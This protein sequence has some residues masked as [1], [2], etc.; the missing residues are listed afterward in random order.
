MNPGLSLLNLSGC[1]LSLSV[2]CPETTFEQ[3]SPISKE[4]AFCF[5]GLSPDLLLLT[6]GTQKSFKFCGWSAQS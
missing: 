5:N 4:D 6:S 1:R 3:V 2:K